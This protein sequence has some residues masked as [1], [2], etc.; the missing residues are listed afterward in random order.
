MADD[1]LRRV[2]KHMSVHL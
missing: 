2:G 1:F